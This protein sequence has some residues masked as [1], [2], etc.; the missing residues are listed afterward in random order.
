MEGEM[1]VLGH[2][3]GASSL[4]WHL[5]DLIVNFTV[6]MMAAVSTSETSVNFYQTTRRDSPEDSHN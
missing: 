1:P 4:T 3:L 2:K 6:L 5:P